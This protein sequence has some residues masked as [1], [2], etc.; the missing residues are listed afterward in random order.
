MPMNN[1][2]QTSLVLFFTR[3]M[4][5]KKWGDI[6]LIDRE[7][8]LYRSLRPY[9]QNIKFVTYGG[10]SDLSYT[11]RV[12]DIRVIC[13]R[14]GLPEQW[15]TSFL[16]RV[17]PMLWRGGHTIVK[18]NQVEGAEIALKV[19]QR[20]GI[21]FLA[22]CGY[23]PS[24]IYSLR[25]GK[26]SPESQEAK[27][28]ESTVF[29]AADCVVV[30][31]SAMYQ[32]LIERYGI[33]RNKLRI[34]PN[35]VDMQRFKPFTDSREPNLLCYIGRLEKGKNVHALLDAIYGLDVKLVVIGGGNLKGELMT[36][37][38]EKRLNVDFLGNVPHNELPAY[39]NR[40]SL[41]IL[42]SYM[43]HHPKSLLEAMACSLPVIGTDVPGIRELIHHRETGYLCGT[44]SK[45]IR[46]AI[47]DVLSNANLCNYMGKNARDFVKEHFALERIVDMELTL[48]HELAK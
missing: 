35:Y 44:S 18:S 12:N 23:L 46:D 32:T 3:G 8:A 30:T 7:V 17:Y 13:N 48:L 43:E 5:L 14:W 27:Q 33:K 38:K 24:N 41:F 11:D 40:A 1:L 10:A 15:Y 2:G 47:K 36:K 42:P 4:S 34:V 45:E 22:R 37:V 9:M 31:T 26:D 21:K 19:A 16:T 25:Y 29:H 6:G 39:L 28:L 20:F